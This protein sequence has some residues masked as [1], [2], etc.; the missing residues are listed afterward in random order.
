MIPLCGG[1]FSKTTFSISLCGILLFYIF[2]ISKENNQTRFGLNHVLLFAMLLWQILALFT[3]TNK[4]E[5]LFGILFWLFM[6]LVTHA[7]QQYFQNVENAYFHYNVCLFA[8]GVIAAIQNH[9]AA[10]L[11]KTDA[12]VYRFSKGI[13]YAN[14]LAMF[15]LISMIVGLHMLFKRKLSKKIKI[16]VVLGEIVLL[17]AFI[18]TFSRISWVLGIVALLISLFVFSKDK[19]PKQKIAIIITAMLAVLVVAALMPQVRQRISQINFQSTELNERFAYYHDSLQII[20]DN[21]VIGIGSGGWSSR[22]AEFQSALYAARYIHC[23]FLQVAVDSGLPSL[24]LYI[25]ICVY[26]MFKR[27]LSK[28]KREQ[29]MLPLICN[30][31]MLSHSLLD[32]DFSIPAMFAIFLINNVYILSVVGDITFTRR[33]NF[34][35]KK[36]F[37]STLFIYLLLLSVSEVVNTAGAKEYRQGNYQQAHQLLNIAGTLNPLNSDAIY[38]DGYAYKNQFVTSKLESDKITAINLLEKAQ[39]LDKYNP[40]YDKAMAE[41]YLLSGEL[42]KACGYIEKVIELQPLYGENYAI[43]EQCL[44]ELKEE[45]TTADEIAAVQKKI[46]EIPQKI[47]QAK[48]RYSYWTF[49]VQHTPTFNV[50]IK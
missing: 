14:A 5:C 35:V 47:E 31:I 18:Q 22:Q 44:V 21:P 9:V 11:Y 48:S 19:I 24:A 40:K 13:P 8:V 50:N 36:I 6:C 27:L 29:I 46:D 16:Y 2:A 4:Y 12:Q 41:T 42:E 1:Y 15:L 28:N 25:L 23:S 20:K 30:A 37:M 43:Y 49:R 10:L 39:K 3:G 38:I 32:F 26:P 33:M 45:K 7:A 17:S 34:K